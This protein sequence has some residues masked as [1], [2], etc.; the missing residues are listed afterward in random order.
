MLQTVLLAVLTT[1]G[2]SGFAAAGEEEVVSK[3][4]VAKRELLKVLRGLRDGVAVNILRF[5][6]LV[7]P[8]RPATEK[9]SRRVRLDAATF[10]KASTPEGLANLSEALEL[11]FQDENVDT[12][13]LL[14]D[15]APTTGKHVR[16]DEILAEVARL[17][18]L[19]KVKIH[20]IGFHLK[21]P[22]KRLL[23]E[24]ADRNFGVFISR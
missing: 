13:Y 12:I 10:V 7:F 8:W 24:L 14:S 1:S 9:L 3:I 19:R 17:N 4:E 18:R 22:E 23:R 16:P 15:G 20:T 2:L 5:N 6:T 11:A 21:E